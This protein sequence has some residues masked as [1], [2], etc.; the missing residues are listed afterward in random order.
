MNKNSQ[1]KREA[2]NV[3]VNDRR[4][5]IDIGSN[6]VRLV[7][8]EGAARAPL[9]ICNEKA[10][11]GLGRN[12]QADGSLNKE[13]MDAALE[14]LA[15][16][17][18]LLKELGDPKT[19]AVATAAVRDAPNAKEFIAA[20]NDVGFDVTPIS[21]VDEARLA[22]LG[23]I[24]FSPRAQGIVGDMGGGSLELARVKKQQVGE[25]ASL[26]LGPLSLTQRSGAK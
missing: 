15:R 24:S 17:R 18:E 23:A 9:A 16:F 3:A 4:A 20:A 22:A 2:N 21:G 12:T 6:S 14:T 26:R 19:R 13:A 8:Y 5:I 10:L 11:C 1:K 25:C 7:V